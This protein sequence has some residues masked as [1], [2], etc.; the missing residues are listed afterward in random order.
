MS[1]LLIHL[2]YCT[3]ASWDSRHTTRYCSRSTGDTQDTNTVIEQSVNTTDRDVRKRT[4]GSQQI[5]GW[6]NKEHRSNQSVQWDDEADQALQNTVI[7]SLGG[8]QYT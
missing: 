7:V 1:F 4:F 3:P 5:T 8:K 2:Q 6:A